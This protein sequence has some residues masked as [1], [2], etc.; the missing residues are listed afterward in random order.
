MN[1]AE[2][3]AMVSDNLG[4]TTDGWFRSSGGVVALSKRKVQVTCNEDNPEAAMLY[5][6]EVYNVVGF[7][8]DNDYDSFAIE[9]KNCKS[10]PWAVGYEYFD[11]A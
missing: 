7:R 5:K 11:L 1:K 8:G 3:D 6:G 4:D 9:D 10:S 2:F